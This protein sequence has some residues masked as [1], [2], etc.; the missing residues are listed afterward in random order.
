MQVYIDLRLRPDPEI[1]AHQI[2]AAVFSR[3][4]L[5]LVQA[6]RT[7]I[8]VSFPLHDMRAPTLGA[9]LRLHGSIPALQ[10][11]ADT[12]WLHGLR[13][14]A[15]VQPLSEVPAVCV[16]RVVSRVQAHSGI[17]R[18]RRRA[19]RRKGWS[20][21]EARQRIP[22]GVQER[23]RLPFVTI[24]SRSTVQPS[25]PLFIRH[26]PLL[27]EPVVGSFNSYGLSPRATVPWF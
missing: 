10:A 14:Y 12:G 17:E 22:D 15:Q 9:L 16:H 19:M 18:M 4:H 5:A 3:L 13:D 26:G 7:D 1:A 23:L 2:L 11:L 27:P 25:F 20:A 24:G 8:G 6:G 21:D